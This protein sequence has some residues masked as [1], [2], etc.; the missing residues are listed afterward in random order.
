MKTLALLDV[1]HSDYFRGY[2][3]PVIAIP[4][5]S[6]MTNKEVAERIREEINFCWEYLRNG[7]SKTE[8]LLMGK[9][10][11]ELDNEP[12]ELYYVLDEEPEED[13]DPIYMYFGF[14]F[15]S[16]IRVINR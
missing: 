15:I 10:C 4:V 6:T 9:L 12:N 13:D 11:E 7:Y 5:Y 3:K 1:C 2:H 8:M 16:H 14:V